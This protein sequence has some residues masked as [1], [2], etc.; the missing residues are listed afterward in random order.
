MR[1]LLSGE[2]ATDIGTTC[3]GLLGHEFVPGPMAKIVDTLLEARLGYSILD[4]R[5]ADP[6]SVRHV[7]EQDLSAL[8]REAP[9]LLPGWRAGKGKGSG[10][11]TRNAELL[12]LRA[13]LD[14]EELKRPTIAVLFRDSDG[15]NASSRDEWQEKFESMVKGFERAEFDAGVPMLPRPKSE[16]WLLC[17]LKAN[18]YIRCDAL[19]DES[20]NDAA[21]NSLKRQ[22]ESAAGGH[23]GPTD[24]ADWI[25]TRIDPTRVDMP[26][27]TA[28]RDHLDVAAANALA[29]TP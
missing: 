18:P 9:T 8:K 21:P 10:Y 11:Y 22:L 13:R 25:N 26:S 3:P 19:E 27:Y 28:F 29:F 23:V 15:T 16:A 1:L 24:M 17:G 20:G 4:H 5:D 7:S 14:R 6:D 2:G 12:G